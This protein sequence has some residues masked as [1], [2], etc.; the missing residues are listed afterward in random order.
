[1]KSNHETTVLVAEYF[2]DAEIQT[3]KDDFPDVTFL[4]LKHNIAT[5][6]EYSRGDVLL[7]AAM[8]K[9][10][11]A[12]VLRYASDIR[13]IHTSTAGFDWLLLPEVIEGIDKG[14]LEVTRSAST[15]SRAI[16]EFVVGAIFL[17]A[18]KFPELLNA[19][20]ERKW[21][22]TEPLELSQMTLGIVGAG[23]IG[24]EVAWRARALGMRII[25]IQRTPKATENFDEVLPP[26][27]LLKLMH[28]SDIVV[29]AMPLTSET[30]HMIA[31][32][33]LR[34]MKV[35][36]YLINVGRG[37]LVDMKALKQALRETWIAGALLDVFDTEPLPEDDDLWDL[38]NLIV[39]PH[40]S[41]R[42]PYNSERILAEFSDNLRRFIND[43]P[44]VNTMRNPTL[45]Y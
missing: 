2:S 42:S 15:Y 19:Q 31:E 37:A 28:A 30:R 3:L 10:E 38:P 23:A 22:V 21:T 26:D 4:Q 20:A 8:S 27:Q 14:H 29:L 6:S 11:L 12:N 34:A 5:H 32:P 35:S 33:E 17:L 7:R 1:M 39:T 9:E 41:F 25:G 18:K 36:A 40:T 13:W 24:S 43:E 44:L 45:G 16:G